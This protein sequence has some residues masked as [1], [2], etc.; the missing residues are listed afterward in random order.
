MVNV[1]SEFKYPI[2]QGGMANISTHELASAV[3]LAGGLGI[4]G[5]GGYDAPTAEQE[6][7]KMKEIVGDRPF[8]ANLMLM[9]PH[10]SDI[11]DVCIKH[12]VKY[13]TTGAGNPGKYVA[14]CHENNMVILPVVPSVALAKRMEKIG[15]DGVIVEGTES[16]GHVGEATTMSLV[17]QVCRAVNID[18]IAAGGIASNSQF[19]AAIALGSIG[20]QIGTILLA[21]EECPIH[22][23]YKELIINAKDTSTLVTGRVKGVPVRSIRTKM[24]KEYQKL[25]FSDV[26]PMELEK[27]T[28]GSLRKAVLEGDVDH[29]SFMAGQ[30]AGLI[31]EI[32]PVREIFESL[33]NSDDVLKHM[34]NV[35]DKINKN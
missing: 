15:C 5:T 7:I 18:V 30:V 24:T 31:S 8:G 13:I 3:C 12:N 27:L 26:D 33:V 14:K 32:K 11:L 35:Y 9:N 28:L 19:M 20:V 2:I 17:P 23:N 29:G 34:E 4:I 25:E 6:I 10:V 22:Q 21:S 16:G 1:L